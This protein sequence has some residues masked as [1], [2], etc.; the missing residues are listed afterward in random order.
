MDEN[1]TEFCNL[2]LQCAG[3]IVRHLAEVSTLSESLQR[4]PVSRDWPLVLLED[5]LQ[6]PEM[7]DQQGT[8]DLTAL[9]PSS[10]GTSFPVPY[11][12]RVAA[13]KF[14]HRR[15]LSP[16]APG[17]AGVSVKPPE[18]TEEDRAPHTEVCTSLP[19]GGL[20][21]GSWR[22]CC[23][24]RLAEDLLDKITV[25]RSVFCFE[26]PGRECHPAP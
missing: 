10:E 22:W 7:I 26:D 12:S 21:S 17:V 9:A 23:Q 6:C 4:E 11:C 19:Q 14:A 25:R 5:P 24:D 8:T 1:Q 20:H 13:E 2:F 15:S 3:P 16:E 18:G